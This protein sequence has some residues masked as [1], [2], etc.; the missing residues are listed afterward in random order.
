MHRIGII[1]DTHGLLREEVKAELRGCDAILHGGDSKEEGVLEE[2]RKIGPLYAVRGNVDGE[3]AK[4][5]PVLL[6]TELFGLR[7]TMIHNRE[8]LPKELGEAD[9]VVFGHSH[10]FTDEM[11]GGVRF[12]NPG[13]CGPKRF[14]RPVTM[15][16]AEVEGG[17][18]QG[19]KKVEFGKKE[20][21]NI[22]GMPK[23]EQDRR[24]LVQAVM[25]D[26]DKGR[27]VKEIARN[28]HIPYELA[29]KICRMYLTHPGVDVD[30]ILNRIS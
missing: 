14:L 16:V 20:A 5:L 13:S 21:Q 18:I 7:I 22:T 12:L 3:W 1:S 27:E 9:L 25:R 4:D 17:K 28:N 29:E 19:I 15:A 24:K 10:K 6:E 2:L 23:E 8:E 26:V 30:G 11:K